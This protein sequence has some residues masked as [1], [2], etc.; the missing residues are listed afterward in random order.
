MMSWTKY[1]VTISCTL[2]TSIFLTLKFAGQ[3]A[4]KE[5]I[6]L[7]LS[8]SRHGFI[9]NESDENKKAPYIKNVSYKN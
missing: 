1:I 7:K 5:L 2:Y 4:E 3:I 9:L 6:Q 8:S